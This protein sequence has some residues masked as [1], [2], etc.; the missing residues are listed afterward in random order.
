MALR[1][2]TPKKDWVVYTWYSHDVYNKGHASDSV[3]PKMTEHDARYL[4][5]KDAG[6]RWV[7]VMTRKR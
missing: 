3:S 6:N 1:P 2:T 7:R 5:T 4:V